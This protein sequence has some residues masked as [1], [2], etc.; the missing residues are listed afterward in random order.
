MSCFI[1]SALD[2]KDILK[3]LQAE[4]ILVSLYV[5]DKETMPEDQQIL[6]DMGNGQIK[7]VKTF[8][9]RWSIFQWTI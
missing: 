6:I 5:E 9:D 3:V 4:F 1:F 7:K 2:D 8:G